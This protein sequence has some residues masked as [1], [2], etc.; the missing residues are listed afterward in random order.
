M[1]SPRSPKK[2]ET[3]EV[4]LSD[5]AKGEFMERCRR[6]QLTA[7]EAIRR[8]IEGNLASPSGLHARRTSSWR[9]LVAAAGGLA[10]GAGMAGT[11]LARPLPAG[12]SQDS[13]AEFDGL[14]RNHDGMLS[15]EEY[16]AR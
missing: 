10:L 12:F 4:R 1:A 7:S 13:R 14:D 3:I 8:F 9:M 2:N 16:R 15:F 6:E 5:Q 11:S